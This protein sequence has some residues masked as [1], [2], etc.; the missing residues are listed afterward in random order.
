MWT[1]PASAQVAPGKPT[2]ASKWAYPILVVKGEQAGGLSTKQS[3][4][5][6]D[7]KQPDF[8][9][10]FLEPYEQFI[11]KQV[12]DMIDENVRPLTENWSS[13][14]ISTV[15]GA[16]E[17]WAQMSGVMNSLQNMGGLQSILG[18][19]SGGNGGGNPLS[20]LMENF[21]RRR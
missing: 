2:A 9:L 7:K 15:P 18:G 20:G 10:V 6:S 21:G 8:V 13:Q 14:V 16:E 5:G 4:A 12:M 3:K 19:A 1:E 11:P 17:A